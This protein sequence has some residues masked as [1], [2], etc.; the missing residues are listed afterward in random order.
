MDSEIAVEDA[1][2][3]ASGMAWA[4]GKDLSTSA[5]KTAVEPGASRRVEEQGQLVLSGLPA[6]RISEGLTATTGILCDWSLVSVPILSELVVVT[7]VITN[8]G[9]VRITSRLSCADPI[10][11]HPATVYLLTQA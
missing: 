9:D 5:R 1:G 2:G 6:Q 11:S 10:L 8:V 3:R 4:L 7:D